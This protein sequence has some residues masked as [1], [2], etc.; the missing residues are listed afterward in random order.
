MKA[1]STV[2]LKKA[3]QGKRTAKLKKKVMKA[4]QKIEK[5]RRSH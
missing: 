4:D 1:V 3:Q 5:E 2:A